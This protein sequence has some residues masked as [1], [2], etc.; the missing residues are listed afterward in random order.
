MFIKLV[1]F[2][3]MIGALSSSAIAI[4]K[5]HFV[6]PG[7]ADFT[8][9]VTFG[10]TSGDNVTEVDFMT[11]WISPVSGLSGASLATI[12]SGTNECAAVV[13]T[14]STRFSVE[15]YLPVSGSTNSHSHFLTEDPIQNIQS[16]FSSGNLSGAGEI[17]SGLG[18]GAQSINLVFEQSDIFMDMTDAT[19]VWNKSFAKPFPSVTMEPQIQVPIIN[20]FHKTKYII[21]AY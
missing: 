1:S 8:N 14:V 6:V 3:F 12:S 9:G 21:K 11:W 19:F 16:D 2:L 7:G 13:D 18:N 20:H 4:D 15:S 5:L 10:P 17:L